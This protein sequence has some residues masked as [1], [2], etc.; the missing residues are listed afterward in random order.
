MSDLQTGLRDYF[1]GV[2]ER[3]SAQDVISQ[4]RVRRQPSLRRGVWVAA[5][6]AA[7]V[8]VG[9]GS[10]V[11]ARWLLRA[12]PKLFGASHRAASAT[13][14]TSWVLPVL[15]GV[16]VILAI[17]AVAVVAYRSR[18]GERMETIERT[19]EVKPRPAS[20]NRWLVVTLAVLLVVALAAIVWLLVAPPGTSLPADGQA[21][22]DEYLAGWNAHDGDAVISAIG[23]GK[24][25]NGSFEYSGGD[26]KT[27]VNNLPDGWAV[28][29]TGRAVVME[30]PFGQA[31]LYLMVLEERIGVDPGLQD[32]FSIFRLTHTANDEW[33]IISHEWMA[34]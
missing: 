17:G 1:D 23:T 11:L 32:G 25:V 2:V 6:A 13:T 3:V 15:I 30:H 20:P 9:V 7:A 29:P 14:T 34:P 8:F 27:L 33:R 16:V 24:H 26:L 12:G 19:T 22:M 31:T 18:K 10:V 21:L 4:V 5:T 28:T